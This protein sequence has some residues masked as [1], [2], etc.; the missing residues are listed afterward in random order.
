VLQPTLDDLAGPAIHHCNLL[1]ARV[2]I[3]PDNEHRSAPF[4]RA[5][6]D[7][8]QPSLLGCEQP[9]TSSNHSLAVVQNLGHVT[10]KLRLQSRLVVENAQIMS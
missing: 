6:A 8:L 2:K 3:T 10:I 4:L 9:T 7:Q 1:K 5:L